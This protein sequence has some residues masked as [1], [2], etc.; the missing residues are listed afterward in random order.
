VDASY[1]GGRAGGDL[2][3]ELKGYEMAETSMKVDVSTSSPI[4][5]M[6]VDT[7]DFGRIFAFMA[8]DAQVAV[9]RSMVHHMEPHSMQW[10]YIA[11]E[12]EKHG[13]ERLRRKLHDIF[14][15]T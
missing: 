13:N 9:L 2:D 10:D 5:R 12:L 1:S 4:L 3:C 15:I 8:S 11:I 6:D 7:N 14:A